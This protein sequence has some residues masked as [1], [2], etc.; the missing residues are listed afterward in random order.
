[1]SN[2]L[3]NIAAEIRK[4]TSEIPYSQKLFDIQFAVMLKM[5]NSQLANS[6]F[7]WR[8]NHESYRSAI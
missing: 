7:D 3:D 2:R 1:M 5:G 6:R 4:A 8:S